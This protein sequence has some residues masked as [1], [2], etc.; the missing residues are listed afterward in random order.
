MARKMMLFLNSAA[1]L[2]ALNDASARTTTTN[3]DPRRW[4]EMKAE[5]GV[6]EIVIYGEIGKSWWDDDA[7]SAKQFDDELK[8]LGEVTQINLRINSPGGDAFDGIAIHNMLKNHKAKVVATVDGIAASAASIIAMAADE[9]IMPQNAFLLIHGASGIAMGNAGDMQSM[10]DDLKRLDLAIVNTY[11]ARS[12]QKADKISA[13]MKEDR[14]MGAS[15]A[16]ELG[17]ADTVKDAVKMAAKYSLRLLPKAAADK[18]KQVAETSPEPAPPQA[19]DG[20]DQG[21]PLKDG[22][23]GPSGE[24]SEQPTNVVQLRTEA[25]AE[26]AAEHAKYVAE[27]LDLCNLSGLP[28]LASKFIASN[29]AVKD[30]RA[31]LLVERS[32][33][34]ADGI[35]PHRQAPNA[36]PAQTSAKAWDKV[37]NVLNERLGFQKKD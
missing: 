36:T 35:N 29:K 13:I 11:A 6:G 15:E 7:M 34:E 24:G 33:A 25:R 23:P 16:N 20:G 4:F 14:L 18:I 21:T 1:M 9:I 30:V 5:A 32:R 27:V 31:E 8:A 22:G 2:L 28:A 10:A 3:A 12:G 17:L 19:Q 26:G 37:V